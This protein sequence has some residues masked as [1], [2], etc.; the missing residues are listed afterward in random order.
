MR[1]T[2]TSTVSRILFLG[3]A[4]L[5]ALAIWEK[6]ANLIGLTVLRG[7]YAPWRLLEFS[8][9]AVLFVIA[10]QLREIHHA[11]GTNAPR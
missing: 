5:A 11:L 9:V 8:V 6:L 10:L 4:L 1:R 3:S 2:I 7:A